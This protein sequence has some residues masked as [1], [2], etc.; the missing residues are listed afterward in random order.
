MNRHSKKV[1]T[2]DIFPGSIKTLFI[3]IGM[4]FT[5]IC[6]GGIF[7]DRRIDR[8]EIEAIVNHKKT[9]KKIQSLETQLFSECNRYLHYD[10]FRMNCHNKNLWLGFPEDFKRCFASM[11]FMF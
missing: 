10:D 1:L 4:P 8:D 2:F 6:P 9:L 3:Y 11:I 7:T 5:E